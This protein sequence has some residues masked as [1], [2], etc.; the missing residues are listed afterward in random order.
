MSGKST[1]HNSPI[2]PPNLHV[3]QNKF[4]DQ[5]L[6]CFLIGPWILIGSQGLCWGITAPNSRLW[7]VSVSSNHGYSGL[8]GR[9][10]CTDPEGRHQKTTSSQE[11]EIIGFSSK[12][13]LRRFDQLLEGTACYLREKEYLFFFTYFI[14][15]QFSH[16]FPRF[17]FIELDYKV[18]FWDK[19]NI[20]VKAFGLSSE[21]VCALY[22]LR[23]LP[24]YPFHLE[25][26][27]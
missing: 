7:P 20:Q 4:A 1:C 21:I 12:G 26:L 15:Q 9:R 18:S 11:E 23:D 19:F 10:T 14:H 8:G 24:A 27:R 6:A 25:Q 16:I 22:H 17:F 5:T 2:G 3:Y 13:G